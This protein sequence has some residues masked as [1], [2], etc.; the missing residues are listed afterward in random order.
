MKTK[1]NKIKL[2]KRLNNKTEY[3]LRSEKEGYEWQIE[4]Y[5]VI[6]LEEPRYE[7]R[8]SVQV[9]FYIGEEKVFRM[10]N[11]F[12]PERRI[13]MIF[14]MKGLHSKKWFIPT[15]PGN[16]KGSYHGL[17]TDINRIDSIR[18]CFNG[19]DAKE[20]PEVEIVIYDM[21]L[22][23]EEPD[24]TVH[25]A[26]LVDEFGQRIGKEWPGKTHSEEELKQAL[27]SEYKEYLENDR[28]ANPDWDRFGGYKKIKFEAK[29]YFYLTKLEGVEWL[30]DPDG[31]AFYSNGFSYGSASRVGCF[32][33]TYKMEELYTWLPE[34][35]DPLY[36]YA[37]T[38]A[39]NNPEYVKR[40]GRG[41]GKDRTMFNFQRANLMRVFGEE[42]L[43]AW[44]V[45]LRGRMKKWGLNTTTIGVDDANDE[46]AHLYAKRLNMPFVYRMQWFPKTERHIFRD[47]PDVY[48]NE[49]QA[50]CE[51]FAKQ[52]IPLVGDENFI[53]YYM[54]NEPEWLTASDETNI[55]VMVLNH[56]EEIVT[57]KVMRKQLVNKYGTIETLNRV[58]GADFAN[59][60][61]VRALEGMN[62]AARE[63]IDELNKQVIKKFWEV[64]SK[65]CAAVAGN[66]LNLG[67]RCASAR[68]E[69]AVTG[70]EELDIFSFNCYDAIPITAAQ[71]VNSKVDKPTITSEWHMGEIGNQLYT[72]GIRGTVGQKER[73]YTC[74]R[75]AY[76]VFTNPRSVGCHYFEYADMPLLGRFDGA[77][78]SIGY[79]DVC[80]RPYQE[81]ME[82]LAGQNYDLYEIHRGEI[83]REYSMDLSNAGFS[84]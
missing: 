25:G 24:F 21:Y 34:K 13:K 1:S 38:V 59:F 75:Y 45:L 43:D 57:A 81:Y 8:C 77:A 3:I 53:G 54:Y 26:P 19:M 18:I 31:Y 11:T 16:L 2:G 58:W 33:F 56:K 40:N 72:P 28:Y 60:E 78:A 29:G 12:I 68:T 41:F 20:D 37:Y 7:H 66:H 82:A 61:E 44:C 84:W 27:M 6:E 5:L 83:T 47:F 71:F 80:C 23:K 9:E 51:V 62:E 67:F 52:I 73:G 36:R 79:I 42:W 35:D 39:D 4:D 55:A 46:P 50:A 70:W 14:P 69:N 15:Q 10:N 32:A 76:H 74:N 48:S 49:Y 22:A 30:V 64:P 17:P 65:A 63:D